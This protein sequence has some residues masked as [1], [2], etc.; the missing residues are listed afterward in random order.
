MS[1]EDGVSLEVEMNKLA[2]FCWLLVPEFAQ[3]AARNLFM[4]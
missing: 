3:L 2:A 4:D 1:K